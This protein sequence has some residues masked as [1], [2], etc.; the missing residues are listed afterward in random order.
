MRLRPATLA[1][2]QAAA[3]LVIA[4]DIADIGVAD[5]SLGDLEDE[6]RELDLDADTR[7]VEDDDATIVGCAHFR[8]SD[9]LAQVDPTR[10][11]EGFGTALLTWSEKR[12]SERGA[13][14]IRQGV[15]DRGKTARALLQAHGYAKTRSFW[16]MERA[17]TT[18]EATADE[19][20]L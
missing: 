16:R 13:T 6:W 4:S 12:A 11:G 8:G 15:G 17:T 5:Y 19:P 18:E 7:L 20:G 10:A 14:K 9:V 1:D 3:N 2:A